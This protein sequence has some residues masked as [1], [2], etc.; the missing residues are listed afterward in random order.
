[1]KEN[2]F[3]AIVHG[4]GVFKRRVLFVTPEAAPFAQ[5]GGLG[6]VA[7][8]LP[9]ALAKLGCEVA[10]V[11]P[12]YKC[13]SYEK[14]KLEMEVRNMP[15]PM[16]MGELSA[17]V[18]SA[19]LSDTHGKVFFIQNDRYFDRD[20]LYGTPDGDFQDN[21]GRF[22]FFSRAVLEMLKAINWYPQIL[23]LNDW[24]TGLTA[25]YLK[26]LYAQIPPY[27]S[28][29]SLFTIHNMAYQ[30]LFP[31]Y[32]LPMTGIGWEEFTQE[33]LEFYDQVN[34]LKAGL[35]YSDAINTVSENY[36]KEI[37]MGEFGH[38]LQG[39]LRARSSVLSGIVNGID[40]GEWNPATDKELP[41]PFTLKSH[42]KK[43]MTKKK[44]TEEFGLEYKPA[45]P[46]VGLFSPLTGQKG[47]DLISE[48]IESVLNMDVQM[49]V[50]GM[51]EVRYHTFFERLKAKFPD[52][53]AVVFK[54]DRQLAKLI[55]AGSDIFLMPSR[56]EP[57]GWGQM[58]AMKY[59]TIPLVRKTGGLADTVENLSE[60]GRKGTGFV[61][62]NYRS[63][64][65][66]S[67]MK[68]AMEAF[69]QPKLWS[70]LIQRAMKQDFSW[71][72]TARKYLELYDR[73]LA[74]R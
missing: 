32:I 50:L 15:V 2:G 22:A 7:G 65:L 61:F 45:T 51:G 72:A 53:L 60:D 16:G 59:G 63:D 30:G 33:K 25:A 57:S 68:R 35:V 21:A 43:A 18:L 56:L 64:E 28:I 58:I 66:L 48:I 54:F 47:L 11:L 49:I 6:D 3:N 17:D 52:K 42:D 34:Y 12:R 38:G 46:V 29:R 41:T 14:Y 4:I 62:E 19:R 55:Y 27:P 71:H 69:R 70:D 8:S 1:L 40:T 74:G 39:V 73:I 20:G 31:K 36:S 37:Q 23:H 26:T 67:A 10:V 24:Q 9:A 44:L 13:V 5:T